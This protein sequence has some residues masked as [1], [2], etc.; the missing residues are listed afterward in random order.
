M[1]IGFANDQ[2]LLQ[3]LVLGQPGFVSQGE[4]VTPEFSLE[5][6]KMMIDPEP[7][8]GSGLRFWDGGL[9]PTCIFSQVTP[10]GYLRIYPW[11]QVG[12]GIGVKQLCREFVKPVLKEF[13][14]NVRQ[15]RDIGDPSMGNSEQSDSEQSAAR[16]IQDELD[17]IFE[18]GTVEWKIRREGV[19]R[20]LVRKVDGAPWVQIAASERQ[21]TRALR[22]GWHYRKDASGRVLRD[23]A[24][25]DMHSHPGDAFSYGSTRV[26]T[27]IDKG[28]LLRVT[29]GP[30]FKAPQV[31]TAHDWN[32][33][34]R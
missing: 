5:L 32:P 33:L 28:I 19:K 2:G 12:R 26:L 8:P 25:K 24:V 7:Y 21:L 17:T 20:S 23:G 27:Y 3:R 10:G 15:W 29:E 4:S 16:A 18:A 6:H 1:A 31:I 9:N 14:P 11:T 13:F 30:R 22:G 34:G